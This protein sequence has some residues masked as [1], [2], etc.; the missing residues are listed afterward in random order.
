MRQTQKNRRDMLKMTAG[1]TVASIGNFGP[2]PALG[3]SAD[4]VRATVAN[5]DAPTTAAV[6]RQPKMCKVEFKEVITMTPLWN[7]S[8]S[9]ESAQ[10]F[11]DLED[12]EP[13]RFEFVNRGALVQHWDEYDAYGDDKGELLEFDA[14]PTPVFRIADPAFRPD[15]LEKSKIQCASLRLRQA[16]DLTEAV[17]RYRDVNLD[18]SPPTVH[19]QEYQAFHVVHFAD[20]I[21]WNRTP[22]QVLEHRRPDGSIRRQRYL[23]HPLDGQRTYWRDDFTP[24]A[25][26]F[27]VFGTSWTLATDALADRVMRA[28]IT[29]LVF[30][31][32]ASDRAQTDEPVF[33]QL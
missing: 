24:P 19:A 8:P 21:D 4:A 1:F 12:A 15:Y 16:L 32:I 25:P 6:P 13:P 18:Q 31:G 33:R 7:I 20:L 23:A 27:R 28:G 3:G 26:L 17:I 9:F 2:S 10:H 30:V 14:M 29:D 5:K 11:F 22:G